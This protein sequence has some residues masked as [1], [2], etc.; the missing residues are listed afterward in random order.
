MSGKA[1][2]GRRRNRKGNT[3]VRLLTAVL[4]IISVV[5]TLENSGFFNETVIYE[6]SGI[7]YYQNPVSPTAEPCYSG[8]ALMETV[9]EGNE[10]NNL[11]VFKDGVP[12]PRTSRTDIIGDGKDV[13]T[14]MIYMCGSDSESKFGLASDDIA[15]ML[16]AEKSGK[17]NI[18]LQTGGSASW[19]NPSIKNQ[20]CRR[21]KIS[22]GKMTSLSTG[23]GVNM[24]NYAN[25]TSF[26][27]F[28]KNNYP[29]DRYALI[30][31]GNG[32]APS[33]GFG[34]D[35]LNA[36]GESMTI[37]ELNQ[38]LY[39]SDVKFDFIGFDSPVAA[40]FDTAFVANYYADYLIASQETVPETGWNYTNWLSAIAENT[41][42]DTADIAKIIIDDYIAD[43]TEAS[44][45]QTATLSLIDLVDF[46]NLVLP[47]TAD[48]FTKIDEI[49]NDGNY[50]Y[51]ANARAAAREFGGADSDLADLME[52]ADRIRTDE[53]DKLI[54]A[55]KDTV[56][57]NRTTEGVVNAN[58]L[59]IYFPFNNLQETNTAMNIFHRINISDEYFG[60]IRKFANIAFGGRLYYMGDD[61]EQ[62]ATG[63]SKNVA[64]HFSGV[65]FENSIKS[66]YVW[67]DS[68]F[69]EK[70]EDYF[71]SKTLRTDAFT[72]SQAVTEQGESYDVIYLTDEQ[73]QLVSDVTAEAFMYVSSS[74]CYLSLG[75]SFPELTYMNNDLLHLLPL[76]RSTCLAIDGVYVD[77]TVI[78]RDI[79]TDVDR[80]TYSVPVTVTTSA[81]DT[82]E[83]VSYPAALHI[84]KEY[85]RQQKSVDFTIACAEIAY[86]TESDTIS[87]K[88]TLNEGDIITP[89][90]RYF[91]GNFNEV[92][93]DITSAD[94][95]IE[96]SL[97]TSVTA[98]DISA[99]ED[100]VIYCAFTDVYG[101][102]FRTEIN[103]D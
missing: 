70:C 61:S 15:E 94:N 50:P 40:S 2:I 6:P 67:V 45:D 48:F 29:A 32:G 80:I 10:E 33:G 47:C 66:N 52:L 7:S 4:I 98:E 69:I 92:H 81:S 41:S 28:C 5:L 102:V 8:A 68:E 30:L 96:Y 77:S 63:I 24:T 99:V 27:V 60:T 26:I 65:D 75:T 97:T 39:A 89:R 42:L 93:P 56:K 3:A 55:L 58:G 76:D 36:S 103:F 84:I 17:L 88:V 91:D 23:N 71:R 95:S 90:Y 51:I 46:N 34:Y 64:E 11:T 37:D 54:K 57:Y 22:K 13:F 83:P 72:F 82:E 100:S 12:G 49:I 1:S 31:W 78:S 18:I 62:P 74:D 25:L 87:R 19:E 21:F 14:V 35:E 86:G 9:S 53:G 43:C 44:A 16:A 79:S 20:D 85:N 73:W 38:A 101:N 59:S